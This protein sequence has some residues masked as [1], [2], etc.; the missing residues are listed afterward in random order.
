MK[1]EFCVSLI[2][3]TLHERIIR[4]VFSPTIHALLLYG[5]MALAIISM[6]AEAAASSYYYYSD[7]CGHTW[8]QQTASGKRYWWGIASSADG[9]HLAAIEYNG[10]IYTSNDNGTTWTAQTT[11]GQRGWVSITSSQD[12]TQLAAVENDALTDGGIWQGTYNG[13]SWSWSS[14]HATTNNYWMAIAS[15]ADGSRLYAGDYSGKVY[16]SSN[17]WG[18]QNVGNH[19]YSIATSTDGKDVFAG[20]VNWYLYF[21]LDNGTMYAAADASNATNNG[22]LGNLGVRYWWSIATGSS[23]ASGDVFAVDGTGGNVISFN[24]ANTLSAINTGLSGKNLTSVSYDNYIDNANNTEDFLAATDFG[25]SSA[26]GYIYTTS[27]TTGNGTSASTIGTWTAENTDNAT[28]VWS[29]VVV[30][31]GSG[32]NGLQITATELGG[33]IWTRTQKHPKYQVAIDKGT[34]T[35]N[36]TVFSTSSTITWNGNLGTTDNSFTCPDYATLIAQ[37]SDISSTFDGWVG[38]DSTSGAKC[39]VWMT[40]AKSI[41]AV[42]GLSA[43]DHEMTVTTS[44]SGTGTVTSSPTGISCG[45][46]GS[47]CSST[48]PHNYAVTLTATPDSGNSFLQWTGCTSASGT[49]CNVTMSANKTVAAVFKSGVTPSYT[50]TVAETGT[51]SGTVT[52]SSGSLSWSGTTGTASYTSGTSVTLTA[53]PDSGSSFSSWTGCDSTSGSTCTVTMSA[54]KS[55]TAAFTLGAS[56]TLSVTKAGVGSGTVTASSGSLS[57]SGTTGTASYTSGTSVTLTATP[58]FGSVF[59]GWTGCD[60]TSGSNCTVAMS[61][62]RSVTA[63]FSLGTSYILNVTKTGTGSGTVTASSGTLSWSGSAGTASYTSGTSVTLTATPASGSAFSGWTGCDSSSGSNCT[64]TMSATRSVTATF[65]QTSFTVT[66]S[67]GA[68]GT[69]SPSAAQIVSSGSTTVFTVTPNAGYTAL[70]GGTCGGQLVG[71]TYTTNAITANCTVAATFTS[72][73]QYGIAATA[74]SAIYNQYTSF[75][76]TKSGDVTRV[77]DSNGTYYVQWYTNGAAIVAW[78]DGY[79]YSYYS[80]QWYSMGVTWNDYGKASSLINSFYSQYSS[81]FGTKSGGISTGTTSSGTYYIQWYTNG[82]AIVAWTDG[83]MYYWDGSKL[84]HIGV[85]WSD[86]T[87]ASMWINV[88]YGQYSSSFGTKSGGIVTGTSGS[89][90]YY[91]QWFANGTAIVAYTDGYMYSYYNG[92]WYALGVSWK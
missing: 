57:W 68:N 19:V 36:G 56:Y 66:P 33:Y 73:P 14:N 3:K 59:S 5:I 63:T 30:T 46:G 81:Y 23:G 39:T 55:V 12:G 88:I 80:G 75:F 18:S 17:N 22:V 74:I 15:S 67:A 4:K 13:S 16:K 49:T 2:G 45:S 7:T 43:T 34:G 87:V 90:T 25:T 76:G 6:A 10:Y 69:I 50:L 47:S 11:P 65:T 70:V 21:S 72:D 91:V 53:T 62:A 61:A 54:A 48:F 29:S 84:Q 41:K 92:A 51:G 40:S 83:Y 35:G 37:T 9:V 85:V 1:K 60:S 89:A 31:N 28:H 82:T 58:A 78:T 8:T 38:C 42:F 79:M 24:P 86:A 64:V 77:T 27:A 52:T 71:T 20:T 44:G 26:G 32:T